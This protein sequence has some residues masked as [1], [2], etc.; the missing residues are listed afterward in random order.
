MGF[1]RRAPVPRE[2]HG[3]GAERGF[4]PLELFPALALV[5]AGRGEGGV[6]RPR[7]GRCTSTRRWCAS[8]SFAMRLPSVIALKEYMPAARRPA[9]TRFNVF[10]RDRFACQYCG[11][12]FQAH[13]LTFDHVVPRSRGGRTT[14][15]NV[16]HRLRRRATCPRATG[17]RGECGMYPRARARASRRAGSCRRTGAP[18]RRTTCTR[19]GATTCTGTSSW[20]SRRRIGRS[21]PGACAALSAGQRSR[22]RLLP[23]L[24]DA[25]KP[26][27]DTVGR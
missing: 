22:R 17:C 4:P 2:L 8:P 12:R 7:L 3:A 21:D 27:P 20:R 16:V 18:S 9:F 24:H 11:E 23:L 25:G 15:R 1:P 19:A 13:E 6:P 14:W 26:L 5:L 10:L